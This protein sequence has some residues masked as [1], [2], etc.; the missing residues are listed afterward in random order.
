MAEPL[1]VNTQGVGQLRHL[2]KQETVRV[3]LE[4]GVEVSIRIIAG[5]VTWLYFNPLRNFL[6]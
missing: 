2:S 3:I 6:Q 5:A 1:E 4:V